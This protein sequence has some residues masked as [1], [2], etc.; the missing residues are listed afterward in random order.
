MPYLLAEIPLEEY[1]DPLIG[2][3]IVSF[4]KDAAAGRELSETGLDEAAAAELSRAVMSAVP[5]E[6]LMGLF[7]ECIA[8]I[9]RAI[10]QN[11]YEEQRLLADALDH[12]GNT[13][14][15]LTALREASRLKK[16]MDGLNSGKKFSG[17]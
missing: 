4:A 3:I 10:L 15:A 16:E 11:K 7:E 1:P 13:E 2:G 8:V 17:N 12:K 6:D 9:R 14:G 5:G